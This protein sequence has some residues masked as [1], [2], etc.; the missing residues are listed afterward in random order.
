[1]TGH[2]PFI[3]VIELPDRNDRHVLAAAIRSGAQVIVTENLRDFPADKL[4]EY[5]IEALTADDF[6]VNTYTL[7][8]S[9]GARSLR[10][11]RKMYQAPP[12]TTAEFILDLT[13]SGLPKLAAAA[14]VDIE[15][16]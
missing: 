1:M 3:D 4:E 7:F 8:R 12:F 5:D 11:V 14:R 6:L 9:D 16:L 10:M 13:K 15:F 2:E